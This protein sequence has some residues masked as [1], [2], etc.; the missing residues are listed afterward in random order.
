[1]YDLER[2]TVSDRAIEK[3]R[4]QFRAG[5]RRSGYLGGDFTGT[6]S[7]GADAEVAAATSKRRRAN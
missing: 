3:V 1:M 5:K 7:D 4:Q 6:D 2:G